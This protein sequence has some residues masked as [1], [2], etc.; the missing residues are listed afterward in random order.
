MGAEKLGQP[1]PESNFVSELKSGVPQQA[2][3]NVPSSWRSQYSPVKAGSVPARRVTWNC[4]G[5]SCS[6]HSASDFATFA[7]FPLLTE[8]SAGQPPRAL[9][10]SV[11]FHSK[12]FEPG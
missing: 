3:R 4:S 12:H 2:H 5:V 11:R 7:I 6:C 10:E 9:P 1:V 8:P